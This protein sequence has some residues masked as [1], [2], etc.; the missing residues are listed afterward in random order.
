M[1]PLIWRHRGY[2][3]TENCNVWIR[4]STFRAHSFIPKR[5]AHF[6]HKTHTPTTKNTRTEKQRHTLK[7][8]W[9]R[10]N[11]QGQRA[12]ECPIQNDNNTGM[13]PLIGTPLEVCNF[14]RDYSSYLKP[15]PWH[16]PPFGLP[17]W[18]IIRPCWQNLLRVIK[19][20]KNPFALGL[21]VLG[22][23][24]FWRWACQ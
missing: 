13:Y 20:L 4:M 24:H 3:C 22:W 7:N 10:T 16:T 18:W 6:V 12:T 1:T 9:V 23:K 11:L 17:E 19:V 15:P 2:K 21:P 8:L 14:G 5:K